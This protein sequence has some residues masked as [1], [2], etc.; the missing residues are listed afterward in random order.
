VDESA[1]L[2]AVFAGFAVDVELFLET[3]LGCGFWPAHSTGIASKAHGKIQ[4][5]F[6]I[7][8]LAKGFRG[9]F[10]LPS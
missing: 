5:C 7:L 2:G 9:K 4:R 8:N 6:I 1:D 10:L 3:G